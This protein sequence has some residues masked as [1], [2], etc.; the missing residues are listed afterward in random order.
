MKKSTIRR[1]GDN[2]RR[3][4]I[5]REKMHIQF[6]ESYNKVKLITPRHASEPNPY[7]TFIQPGKPKPPPRPQTPSMNNHINM[8]SSSPSSEYIPPPPRR[9][10]DFTNNTEDYIPPPPPRTSSNSIP[11]PPRK[12]LNNQAPPRTNSIPPPPRRRVASPPNNVDE[13]KPPPRPKSFSGRINNGNNDN[14]DSIAARSNND[15]T[16]LNINDVHNLMDVTDCNMENAVAALQETNGSLELAIDFIIYNNS[17]NNNNNNNNNNST[18]V[19]MNMLN[20]N[21]VDEEDFFA[22]EEDEDNEGNSANNIYENLPPAPP[23]RR[24]D[25]SDESIYDNLPPAPPRRKNMDSNINNSSPTPPPV[26]P[27][28]H[29]ILNNDDDDDAT[30]RSPSIIR[31]ER[32]SIQDKPPPVPPSHHVINDE[33]DDDNNNNIKNTSPSSIIHAKRDNTNGKL[34]PSSPPVPPL[35]S[36]NKADN[37]IRSIDD[38]N[39][40]KGS[41]PVPPLPS[42]RPAKRGITFKSNIQNQMVL[43]E[44]EQKSSLYNNN[45]ISKNDI[46]K[47]MVKSINNKKKAEISSKTKVNTKKAITTSAPP[48]PAPLPS[49]R[50]AKR[51]I[52]FKS[53]L[54][55]KIDEMDAQ[56]E[57]LQ[58][59]ADALAAKEGNKKDVIRNNYYEEDDEDDGIIEITTEAKSK[60]FVYAGLGGSKPAP[61]L[62]KQELNAKLQNGKKTSAAPPPLPFRPAMIHRHNN[63]T[64]FEEEGEDD[65]GIIEITTEAKS[66]PFVYAGLGG[67]KLQRQRQRPP[68]RPVNSYSKKYSYKSLGAMKKSNNSMEKPASPQL[69]PRRPTSYSYDEEEDREKRKVARRLSAR[70][71]GLWQNVINDEG[72]DGMEI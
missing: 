10:I 45:T 63:N 19:P 62:F 12:N 18:G 31:G 53:N 20:D 17:N 56:L 67:Q 25:N 27:S 46:V 4:R 59:E 30:N 21:N 38:L 69:P 2:R 1:Y 32:N 48:R 5:L 49:R 50:P 61:P 44:E 60:P 22:G 39:T 36:Q 43:Q 7:N 26:P 55:K 11:P 66:K 16:Y 42:R 51:E 33:N 15:S 54:Q 65:D 40:A 68:P 3:K 72:D 70:G 71:K 9:D 41:P 14:D 35:P 58:M 34:L 13:E 57:R 52:K 47:D 8:F 64:K 6:D 29:V 28:R 24:N 37:K 23:R